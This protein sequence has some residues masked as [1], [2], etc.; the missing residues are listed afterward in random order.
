MWEKCGTKIFNE[1]NEVKKSVVFFGSAIYQFS[2][3]SCSKYQ[4]SSVLR[5]DLLSQHP[6]PKSGADLRLC[7]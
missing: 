7:S 6:S 2:S 4:F 1:I 5:G 3:V